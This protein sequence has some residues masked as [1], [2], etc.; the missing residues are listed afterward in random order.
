M[1]AVNVAVRGTATQSTVLSIN[2]HSAAL[3]QADHAID[4][5]RDSNWLHGSCSSTAVQYRPWWRVDLGQVYKIGSVTIT[6]RADRGAELPNG[7]QIRIGYSLRSNGNTNPVNESERYNKGGVVLLGASKKAKRAVKL[8]ASFLRHAARPLTVLPTT[9]V[10]L[11]TKSKVETE[12]KS[13]RSHFWHSHNTFTTPLLFQRQHATPV[14]TASQRDQSGRP[15]PW[16]PEGPTGKIWVTC[17]QLCFN[18]E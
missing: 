18:E 4:G 12:A 13:L 9:A 16:E 6:A 3:S 8:G 2:T 15:Q 11:N 7:A 17:T 1:L 10:S 5:N 14:C